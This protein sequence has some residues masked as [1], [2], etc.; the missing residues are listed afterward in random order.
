VGNKRGVQRCCSGQHQGLFH[1][2][3]YAGS[4]VNPSINPGV[5]GRYGPVLNEL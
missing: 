3:D 1:L 4:F 5:I 2:H